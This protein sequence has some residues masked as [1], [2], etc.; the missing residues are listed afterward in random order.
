MYLSYTQPITRFTKIQHVVFCA[1]AYTEKDVQNFIR[2]F[3]FAVMNRKNIVC[4]QTAI[5]S[6]IHQLTGW[7]ISFINKT[8]KGMV[9]RKELIR[10]GYKQ[11]QYNPQF[12]NRVIVM[13]SSQLGYDG[14]PALF[15]EKEL[16][17]IDGIHRLVKELPKDRLQ[18]KDE[19]DEEND[20]QLKEQIHQ[21]KQDSE[22]LRE[23]SVEIKLLLQEVLSIVKKY[24]PEEAV[25][26]ERHLRLVKIDD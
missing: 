15:S 11:I 16:Q 2:H 4:F 9:T 7:E 22:K 3:I 23:E 13:T 25:K 19:T 26:I 24:E 8:I 17:L 1:M 10:R 21:L 12:A 6:V 18:E 20:M 14:E 5:G